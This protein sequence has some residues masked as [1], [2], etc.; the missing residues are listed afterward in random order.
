MP[1]VGKKLVVLRADE[2]PAARPLEIKDILRDVVNVLGNKIL[3]N[4]EQAWQIDDD[5]PKVLGNELNLKQIFMNLMI[6]ALES[7]PQ[8]QPGLLYVS[9]RA[10]RPDWVL[11]EIADNGPGI[12]L[13]GQDRIFELH[14][15]TKPSK[16]GGIGLYVV[17]SLVDQLQAAMI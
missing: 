8:N 7:I 10:D 2:K 5:L 4:I 16:E 17:K 12:P 6:N 13:D 15:T 3:P 11:V 9:V 14:F 1:L